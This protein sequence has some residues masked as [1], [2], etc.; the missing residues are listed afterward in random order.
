MEF[1]LYSCCKYEI[2]YEMFCAFITDMDAEAGFQCTVA[3]IN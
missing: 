1:L 2:N 3:G